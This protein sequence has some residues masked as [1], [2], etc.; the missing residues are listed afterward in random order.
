MELK[1]DNTQKNTGYIISI[2]ELVWFDFHLS[3]KIKLREIMTHN[4]FLFI[5]FHVSKLH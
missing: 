1:Y 2:H 3:V 5:R 4:R